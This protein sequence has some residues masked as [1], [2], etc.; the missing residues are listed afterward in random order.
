[1]GGLRH[2]SRFGDLVVYQRASRVAEE[3]FKLTKGFPREE[4]YSLTDQIRRASRSIGA[5]IAEAWAKRRYERYFVA[6]LTDAIAEEL[7]TQHWVLVA[8]TCGYLSRERASTLLDELDE[9]GRML[10][11]MIDKADLFCAKGEVREETAMFY[12]PTNH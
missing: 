11:S 9:V 6:K 3:I 2:A 10:H 12:A 7:E 5:Q 4:T 1:M 8:A